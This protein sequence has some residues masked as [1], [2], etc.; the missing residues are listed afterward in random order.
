MGGNGGEFEGGVRV[1]GQNKGEMFRGGFLF[2]W[3]VVFVKG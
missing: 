2:L 1:F 3:A